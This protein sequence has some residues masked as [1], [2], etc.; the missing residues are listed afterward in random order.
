MTKLNSAFPLGLFVNESNIIDVEKLRGKIDFMLVKVNGT[1]DWDSKFADHVNEAYQLDIPCGLVIYID[2]TT[3]DFNWPLND[4]SRWNKDAVVGKYLS[5]SV[6]AKK[7]NFAVMYYHPGRM[8]GSDGKAIEPQWLTQIP[9]YMAEQLHMAWFGS[10]NNVPAAQRRILIGCSELALGLVSNPSTSWRD[11]P[12]MSVVDGLTSQ[13]TWETV[14]EAMNSVDKPAIT[15]VDSRPLWNFDPYPSHNL[16]G[17][18]GAGLV[19]YLGTKT[20]LLSW[21]A[22]EPTGAG[23]GTTPGGGTTDPGTGGGTN[24]GTTVD[25]AILTRIAVALEKMAGIYK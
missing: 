11:W 13:V 3:V 9:I 4:F 1:A 21:C 12:F 10:L 15:P 17:A 23:G 22:Y 24:S 19:A 8:V 2:P 20:N 7:F 16:E 25:N 14:R 5:T 18:G 6:T